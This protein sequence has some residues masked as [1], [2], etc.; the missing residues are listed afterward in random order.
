MPAQNLVNLKA[1]DGSPNRSRTQTLASSAVSCRSS[2]IRPLTYD[3]KLAQRFPLRILVAEDNRLNRKLLVGMLGKLG[4]TAVYEAFDGA[5]AVRMMELSH[6]EEGIGGYIDMIL[7]DL[8]MPNMDGY[9]AAERILAMQRNLG[10]GR[11]CGDGV[12]IMAVT[13]DVTEGTWARARLAGM[14]SLLAKPFSLLDIQ[15]LIVAHY[16]SVTREAVGERRD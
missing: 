8:W 16:A 11:K 3:K 9:E 4:Y 10:E 5:E 6:R 14:V 13:A 2:I 1:G 15:T 7:M 12:K